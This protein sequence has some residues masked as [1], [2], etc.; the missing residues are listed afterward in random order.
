M[1]TMKKNKNTLIFPLLFALAA[2]NNAPEAEEESHVHELIVLSEAQIKMAD[3]TFAPLQAQEIELS[4]LAKGI[5][6]A[7]PENLATL[8]TPYGGYVSFVQVYPGEKVKKGQLLARLKDP[9]YIQMQQEYLSQV[10]KLNFLEKDFER[11]NSLRTT[12]SVSEKTLQEAQRDLEMTR[13][14]VAGLEASLK[15]AGISVASIKA[16]GVQTEVDVRAP[17]TGF[18]TSLNINMGKHMHAG[19]AL[20]EIVNPEHL[21]IEIDVYSSDLPKIKEGQ[22]IYYRISGNSDE[23]TGFIKLINKAVSGDTRSVLVHAHPDDEDDDRL[24][25]GTFIEARLVYGVEKMRVLPLAAVVKNEYN[26]TAYRKTPDGLE[27]ITFEGENIARQWIDASALPDG[28]YVISGA[29]RLVEIEEEGHWALQKNCFG[30]HLFL[31]LLK[32]NPT[33]DVPFV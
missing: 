23:R 19:E 22:K 6:D 7:P 10:S 27:P 12:E 31:K 32:P 5:I 29:S 28:E 20:L 18:V 16:N 1:I 4:F 30:N 26:Y 33:F 14:S 2:C 3:I 13:I 9:V 8:S 25:I 11:K 21:H 15:L 17:I 24:L